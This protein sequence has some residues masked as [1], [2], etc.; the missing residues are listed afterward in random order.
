MVSNRLGSV[1]TP[2][3]L[4]L[5]GYAAAYTFAMAVGTALLIAGMA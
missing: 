5:V 3:N 4:R 1:H 2:H